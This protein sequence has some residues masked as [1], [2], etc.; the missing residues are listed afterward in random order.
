MTLNDLAL[1]E[2]WMDPEEHESAAELIRDIQ[3]SFTVREIPENAFLV[4]RVQ[5]LVLQP[6]AA[7]SSAASPPIR[8]R[9]RPSP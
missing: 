1:G 8:P 3:R 7:A 4:L 6:F 9:P 2:D 5:D